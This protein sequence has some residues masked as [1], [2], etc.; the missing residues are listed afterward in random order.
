MRYVIT[1]EHD[2]DYV[3]LCDGRGYTVFARWL[4][5]GTQIED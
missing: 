4:I 1:F 3:N 5:P 2:G